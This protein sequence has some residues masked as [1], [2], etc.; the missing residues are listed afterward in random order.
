MCPGW[1]GRRVRAG[2]GNVSG[3]ALSCF[4]KLTRLKDLKP[5]RLKAL[6]ALFKLKINNKL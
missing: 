2:A 5:L 3:L 6:K 1:L 4:L